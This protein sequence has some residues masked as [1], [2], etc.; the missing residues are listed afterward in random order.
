M[1]AVLSIGV[2][3]LLIHVLLILNGNWEA[4]SGWSGGVRVLRLTSFGI[5]TL[6]AIAVSFAA[7]PQ[8]RISNYLG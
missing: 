3:V 8:V 4:Q 6:G 1:T 7:F 5:K 2:E